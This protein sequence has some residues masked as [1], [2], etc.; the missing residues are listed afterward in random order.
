M[1]SELA[2]F[3]LRLQP[4]LRVAVFR[5][6]DYARRVLVQPV[7]DAGPALREHLGHGNVGCLRNARPP[8]MVQKR[9][10]ERP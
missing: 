10:D 7:Y 5:R 1:L 8:P 9:V 6:D 3:E 2:R 4:C